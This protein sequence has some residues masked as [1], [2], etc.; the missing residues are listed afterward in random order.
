MHHTILTNKT[1]KK[2]YNN[3]YR[4][5][6]YHHLHIKEFIDRNSEACD[7]SNLIFKKSYP[8]CSW[9]VFRIEK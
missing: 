8:E 1:E 7:K 9:I 2:L 3:I 4:E 6:R 5:G